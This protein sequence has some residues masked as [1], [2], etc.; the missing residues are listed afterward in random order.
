LGFYG[1]VPVPV[2]AKPCERC[3]RLNRENDEL[4]KLQCKAVGKVA[5]QFHEIERL[6]VENEHLREAVRYYAMETTYDFGF[7]GTESME[8]LLSYVEGG[9]A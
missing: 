9:R 8:E 6:R 5:D 2:E 3:K 1:A 7:D 4:N